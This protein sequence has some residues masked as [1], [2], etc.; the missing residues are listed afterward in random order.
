MFKHDT[1]TVDTRPNAEQ[2]E[3]EDPEDERPHK[4]TNK[5]KGQWRLRLAARIARDSKRTRTTT[6]NRPRIN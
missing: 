5:N 6:R 3:G 4:Q 2:R 1:T